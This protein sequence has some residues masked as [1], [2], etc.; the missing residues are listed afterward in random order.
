MIIWPSRKPRSTV[1]GPTRS[2][3][4]N[5][6]PGLITVPSMYCAISCTLWIRFED[7]VP[8]SVVKVEIC[9]RM[10]SRSASRVVRS[11]RICFSRSEARCTGAAAAAAI[12]SAA[13]RTV[14]G[15]TR[16]RG[17]HVNA[18]PVDHEAGVDGTGAPRR[19][20]RLDGLRD[21]PRVEG[22]AEAVAVGAEAEQL[23]EPLGRKR[24]DVLALERERDRLV[25][26]RRGLGDRGFRGRRSSARARRGSAPASACARRSGTPWPASRRAGRGSTAS[27]GR[28][29]MT[30][31][32]LRATTCDRRG[33]G[34]AA[35]T[36]AATSASP[37]GARGPG[38][39]PAP[40]GSGRRAAASCR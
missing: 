29:G 39:R 19:E 31:K 14:D 38:R 40:A 7:D 36:R 34:S 8:M 20:H 22:D 5:V 11:A 13:Q 10:P 25:D 26:Q 3:N 23:H 28:A 21:T 30:R 6:S 4:E 27:P 9:S 15:E 32:S 33:F 17:L 24:A 37:G 35:E 2:L 12:E 16:A 1:R 18:P